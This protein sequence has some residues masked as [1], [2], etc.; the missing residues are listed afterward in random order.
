MHKIFFLADLPVFLHGLNDGILD[1][2]FGFVPIFRILNSSQL[3]FFLLN[4]NLFLFSTRN[5]RSCCVSRSHLNK[6]WNILP[7]KAFVGWLVNW[8]KIV[9]LSWN[10]CASIHDVLFLLVDVFK[11]FRLIHNFKTFLIGVESKLLRVQVIEYGIWR[12]CEGIE[13]RVELLFGS[14]VEDVVLELL[15]LL[16]N[17]CI[18]KKYY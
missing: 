8:I 1:D 13:K 4:W 3:N 15:L 16:L 17:H 11:I 6:I 9:G 14:S 12:S 10:Y 5:Y 18:S 7:Q 2:H